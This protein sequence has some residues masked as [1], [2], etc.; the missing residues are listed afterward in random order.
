MLR[1]A[2][3]FVTLAGIAFYIH[4]AT[5]LDAGYELWAL[6]LGLLLSS[7]ILPVGAV[8]QY[9]RRKEESAVIALLFFVIALMLGWAVV[10]RAAIVY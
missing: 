2:E 6:L 3:F 8:V 1:M 10:S 7:L 5:R 9:R 4:R